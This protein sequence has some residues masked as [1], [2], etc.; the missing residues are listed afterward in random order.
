MT[1]EADTFKHFGVSL[2]WMLTIQQHHQH[3]QHHQHPNNNNNNYNNYNDQLQ[4]QLQ[5]QETG[6]QDGRD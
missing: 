1:I 3:H 5:L 6:L 2:D 4:L